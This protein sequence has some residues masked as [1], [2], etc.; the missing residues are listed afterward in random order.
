MIR[1]LLAIGCITLLSVIPRIAHAGDLYVCKDSH[2]NVAYQDH[3]CPH[4]ATTVGKGQFKSTPYTPSPTVA[5]SSDQSSSEPQPQLIQI[6]QQEPQ[7]PVG[8]ICQAGRRVW[9]QFY[10]CPAT[11]NKAA[12]VNVDGVITGTAAHV[13]GAGTVIIPTPVQ[14]T[15]LDSAGVCTALGNPSIRVQHSGSSDVYERST[16][17]SK[18]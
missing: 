4:S 3:P 18:Y 6:A 8:W 12:P 5:E 13:S 2:G 7:Q 10:P 1:I 16:L 9:L 15:P 17:K 14:A 11:Y